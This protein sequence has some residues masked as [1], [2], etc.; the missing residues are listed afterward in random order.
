MSARPPVRTLAALALCAATA[1][2]AWGEGCAM[3]GLPPAPAAAGSNAASGG[4]SCQ[5]KPSRTVSQAALEAAVAELT[6][7]ADI[8]AQV[9]PAAPAAPP[10]PRV[11]P[12]PA[13]R[14]VPVAVA[15]QR[16][17]AARDSRR[18]RVAND[19][20][21]VVRPGSKFELHS[22]GGQVAIA[23]WPRNAVRI[24]V[25]HAKK[26]YAQMTNAPGLLRVASVSP[27]G[28]AQAFEYRL[29]VPAWMPVS[30]TGV[31]N[32]VT[33]EG[34][35]GG[36]LVHTVRGD[37]EVKRSSGAIELRSVEGFVDL[38]NASGK[39]RVS[40]VND[41][42]RLVKV[43]G[44]V[45]IEAVNGDIQ[46]FDLTSRS[47]EATTLNGAVL[48]DGRMFDDGSY[49]LSTHNGDIALALTERSN[50]TV[51]VSTYAGEFEAPG[52]PIRISRTQPGKR[53]TF[54]IGN[55]NAKVDLESF[56]GAIQLFT[57]GDREVLQRFKE[58][59]REGEAERVREN[60]WIFKGEWLENDHDDE[61]D[62]DDADDEED[63]APVGHR[64]HKSK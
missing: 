24:Q 1:V 53:F 8:L 22:F 64:K 10:A 27:N 59:W 55:G 39:I 14:P 33:A 46:L 52:F 20:T 61:D 6:A 17:R 2:P 32:D 50:A 38:A 40:S 15:R 31:Y 58:S 5:A 4:A 44:D 45:K 49:R 28:P 30:M 12:R 21:L 63:A 37:I 19:T 16:V 35:E 54:A 36:L 41:G 42:V 51:T 11:S 29:T 57:P 56:Q 48:F 62:A 60:K 23:T 9:A 47:V 26:D 3:F 13:P 43:N 7:A 18:A 25:E 34:L